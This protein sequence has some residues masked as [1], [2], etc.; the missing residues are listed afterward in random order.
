MRLKLRLNLWKIKLPK[1]ISA[2]SGEVKP[3]VENRNPVTRKSKYRSKIRIKLK[4]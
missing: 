1:N 3:V 2:I 4:I